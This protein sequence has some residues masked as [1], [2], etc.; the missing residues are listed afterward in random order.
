MI[1]QCILMY[2]DLASKFFEIYIKFEEIMASLSILKV[3][4]LLRKIP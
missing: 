4:S 3:S 1:G 2:W